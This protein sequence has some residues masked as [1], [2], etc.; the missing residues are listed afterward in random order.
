MVS[1]QEL[2]VTIQ[3]IE[4]DSKDLSYKLNQMVGSLEKNA[5]TIYQFAQGSR[6]G[7]NAVHILQ[8]TSSDLASTIVQLQSLSNA[9]KNYIAH[10]ER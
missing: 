10:L 8:E 5:S 7:E 6:S 4:G 3:M 2:S 9:C 1:V